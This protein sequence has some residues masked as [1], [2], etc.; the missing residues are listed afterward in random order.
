MVIFH[1]VLLR[2]VNSMWLQCVNVESSPKHV[3]TFL[4]YAKS[5]TEL[6]H[7]HHQGEEDYVF[8]A[9]EKATG[10]PGIM[11]D[12]IDQ[13]RGF[14][15]GLEE[16]ELY[17]NAAIEGTEKYDGEKTRRL[18]DGFMPILRE[19]LADEIATLLTLD[20][21]EEKADWDALFVNTK[22]LLKKHGLERDGKVRLPAH[23]EK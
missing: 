9:I 7:L 23:D 8:P 10:V 22:A 17:V 6:I 5:I 20:K 13:H 2:L 4:N 18:I 14:E 11:A 15:K 16:F 21:Y 1:N 19:H 3:P 12:E